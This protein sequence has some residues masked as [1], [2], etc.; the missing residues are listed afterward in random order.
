MGKR[1]QS[2]SQGNG[3]ARRKPGPMEAHRF[4]PI[5]S[6]AEKRTREMTEVRN[7]VAELSAASLPRNRRL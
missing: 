7:R 2:Q 4:R 5:E 3:K 1:G 6:K